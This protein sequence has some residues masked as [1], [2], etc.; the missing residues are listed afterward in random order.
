MSVLGL[1]TFPVSSHFTHS[2]MSQLPSHCVMTFGLG[3]FGHVVNG[4]VLHGTAPAPR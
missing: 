3:G 4:Q 2:L 1:G